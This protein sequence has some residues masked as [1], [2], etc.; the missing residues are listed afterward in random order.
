MCSLSFRPACVSPLAISRA[1][2]RVTGSLQ[3]VRIILYAEACLRSM[4][5]LGQP[6]TLRLAH[7]TSP[8]ALNIKASSIGIVR[9]I[10]D[11]Q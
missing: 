3:I 8:P 11:S 9:E 6:A 1:H 2:Q 5:E 10:R 4:A 7:D